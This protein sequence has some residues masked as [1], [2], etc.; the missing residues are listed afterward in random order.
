MGCQRGYSH[1]TAAKAQRAR[2]ACRIARVLPG[3]L[4]RRYRR[5]L[6]V[7]SRCPPLVMVAATFHSDELLTAFLELETRLL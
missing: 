2:I 1:C 5:W 3:L 4:Q 7:D 6:A